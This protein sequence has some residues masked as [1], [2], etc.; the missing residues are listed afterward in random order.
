MYPWVG[1]DQ[2]LSA[3]GGAVD[4]DDDD[5]VPGS[6]EAAAAAALGAPDAGEDAAAAR[7]AARAARRRAA[8]IRDRASL[9]ILA[10]RHD[11]TV[12]GGGDSMGLWLNEDLSFGT[13]GRCLTFEN[14]PLTGAPRT[15]AAAAGGARSFSCVAVEV[16][17]FS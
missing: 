1:R 8:H 17:A 14:E 9:F 11:I 15:A 2:D 16:Y 7:A 4:S 10:T 12:G 6:D 13:T 3:G 5:S